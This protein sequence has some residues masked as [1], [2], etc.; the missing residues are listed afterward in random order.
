M[1]EIFVLQYI[2]GMA[3]VFVLVTVWSYITLR[4]KYVIAPTISS[5]WD[6]IIKE[7]VIGRRLLTIIFFPFAIL[8]FLLLL[9]GK[10]IDLFLLGLSKLVNRL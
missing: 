1:G 10:V 3:I 7:E 4:K 8:Y 6:V 2:I 5:I 9:V